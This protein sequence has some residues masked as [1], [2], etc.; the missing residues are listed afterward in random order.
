MTDGHG[1]GEGGIEGTKRYVSPTDP[2]CAK[3]AYRTP[4]ERLH[5]ETHTQR[6]RAT[7]RAHKSGSEPT[8]RE[9]GDTGTRW[10]GGTRG[11]YSLSRDTL[12][13]PAHARVPDGRRI[14]H[15]FT[16]LSQ[17]KGKRKAKRPEGMDGRDDDTL[18]S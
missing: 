18:S 11:G 7:K 6:R 17:E 2:T 1:E 14:A 13:G 12:A 10:H 16:T 3:G 15:H 4:G 9:P 5:D 8:N